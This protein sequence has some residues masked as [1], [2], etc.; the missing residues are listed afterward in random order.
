MSP[1]GKARTLLTKPFMPALCFLSG[2]T[3]DAVTLTRIDRLQDNLILLV[4]LLLLGVLIVLIGRLGVGPAP[5]HDSVSGSSPATQ[6]VLRM[7]PHYPLAGQFLLG[8]TLQCARGLLSSERHG[9]EHGRL[10]LSVGRTLG[11][12]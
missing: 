3:Y 12:Q 5:D 8:S 1:I 6:W 7:R 9:G 2:V 11:R 4:Y 10:F